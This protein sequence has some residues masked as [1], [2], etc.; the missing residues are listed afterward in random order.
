MF[1]LLS[2]DPISRVFRH[3]NRALREVCVVGRA[4]VDVARVITAALRRLFDP[5]DRDGFDVLLAGHWQFVATAQQPCPR[6]KV[7]Y[8]DRDYKATAEVFHGLK[9]AHTWELLTD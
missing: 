9:R 7:E 5:C 8:P 4:S 1:E 6:D 2:H 3:S